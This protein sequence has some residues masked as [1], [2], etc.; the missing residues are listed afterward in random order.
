MIFRRRTPQAQTPPPC[1]R[2]TLAHPHPVSTPDTAPCAVCHFDRPT[3]PSTATVRGALSLLLPVKRL[4][5]ERCPH[6]GAL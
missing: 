1:A 3:N 6:C 4:D 2:T 5:P